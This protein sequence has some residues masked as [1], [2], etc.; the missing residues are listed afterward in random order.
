MELAP[1]RGRKL[2]HLAVAGHA[3]DAREHELLERRRDF[4]LALRFDNG[5]LA[6]HSREF[7]DEQRNAVRALIDFRNERIGQD[8]APVPAHQFG[9]L[10]PRQ[11]IE[12]E[13]RLVRGCGPRRPKL[14]AEGQHR[15]DAIV[16]P[17]G[18]ELTQKIERRRIDPVQVLNNEEHRLPARAGAQPFV[19]CAKSFFAFAYRCEARGRI[20]L[21]RRQEEELG[22]E[23][24]DFGAAQAA[25]LEALR[26]AIKTR[27]R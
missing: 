19:H 23:R 13:T 8:S 11:S 24:D 10:P 18:N 14:R 6:H 16:Q 5:Q 25:L 21:V 9:D 26:Q 12:R 20:A 4:A 3:I 17:F 7:F 27:G 2:R 15:E 1:E 22:E